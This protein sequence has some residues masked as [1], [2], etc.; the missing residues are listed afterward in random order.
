MSFKNCTLCKSQ[1][2]PRPFLLVSIT[3]QP[4]TC[5]LLCVSLFLFA[6]R[7]IEIHYTV[8]RQ[9]WQKN[10]PSAQLNSHPPL[11]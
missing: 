7:F 3:R 9:R 8:C 2:R 10:I 11:M 5:N 1:R 6:V 4:S